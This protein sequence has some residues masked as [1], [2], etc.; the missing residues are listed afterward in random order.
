MS[1]LINAFYHGMPWLNISTALSAFIV[2]FTAYRALSAWK[3]ELR[4]RRLVQ[5]LDEVNNTFHVC[6]SA[7]KD[8][9]GV[10]YVYQ[11][12]LRSLYEDAENKST[13]DWA[14]KLFDDMDE[15]YTKS[16]S[17][18]LSDA[19]LINNKFEALTSKGHVLNLN[20]YQQFE[21]NCHELLSLLRDARYRI[22]LFLDRNDPHVILPIL[23]ASKSR[24]IHAPW[25][26]GEMRC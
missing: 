4:T 13:C 16:L 15:G 26:L 20:D 19:L 2:A 8:L 7:A 6:Y 24:G 11:L 3:Q 17:N 21:S 22:S 14:Y 18:A 25:G 1:I 23:S 5:Y 10:D 9:C 12:K